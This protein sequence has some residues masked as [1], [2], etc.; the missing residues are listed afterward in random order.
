MA[1]Q[2]I[3]RAD[4]AGVAVDTAGVAVDTAGIAADTFPHKLVVLGS[5]QQEQLARRG[6]PQPVPDL[7]H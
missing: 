4:M 5:L 6:T 7:G 3:P 1:N 2:Q